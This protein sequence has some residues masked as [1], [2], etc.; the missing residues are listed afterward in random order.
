MITKFLKERPFDFMGRRKKVMTVAR[1][2]KKSR[3]DHKKT[4]IARTRPAKAENERKEVRMNE[5]VK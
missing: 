2:K 5:Q 4:K 3:A 1:N